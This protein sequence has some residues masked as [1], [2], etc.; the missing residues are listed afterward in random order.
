[1]HRLMMLST[2]YRQASTMTPSHEKLDPDNRW[3]ARMPLKRMEA[4]AIYDSLLS[5]AGRLDE[6]R[7]GPPDPVDAR[8]DGLVTATKTDK[9]WRRRSTPFKNNRSKTKK[10]SSAV[11]P[12]ESAC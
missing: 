3:L 11:L 10:I 7:F 1:M 5:T 4:E 2:T 6:T 8:K 12:S 9:G